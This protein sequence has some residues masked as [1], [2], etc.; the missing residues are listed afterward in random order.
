MK[1]IQ[2][3]S[4]MEPQAVTSLGFQ[5][6]YLCF[7]NN[8][9]KRE[10]ILFSSVAAGT[11]E[12]LLIMKNSDINLLILPKIYF[13]KPATF[14]LFYYFKKIQRFLCSTAKVNIQFGLDY[15]HLLKTSVSY[16]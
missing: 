10:D 13:V 15:E 16:Y 8:N 14:Q 4:G 1:T 3:C 5:S 2:I 7:N 12:I 11:K 9:K 6:V